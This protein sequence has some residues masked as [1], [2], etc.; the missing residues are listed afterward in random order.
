[1]NRSHQLRRLALAALVTIVV[2]GALVEPSAA[3]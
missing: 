3:A 1:M 2:C